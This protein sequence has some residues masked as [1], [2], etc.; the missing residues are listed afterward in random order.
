M[1]T[2]TTFDF[3]KGPSLDGYELPRLVRERRA[4]SPSGVS[5]FFIKLDDDWGLKVYR[6]ADLRDWMMERQGRAAEIGRG[7]AIGEAV[8]I[9]YDYFAYVS[10]VADTSIFDDDYDDDGTRWHDGEI[11]SSYDE[12]WGDALDEL[13]SDL[14][15]IGIGFSD[16]HHGNVGIIDDRLVCIDFGG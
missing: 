8:D 9:G 2:Q 3:V 6:D 13:H 15:S 14:S 10:Q 12:D 5:S 11:I 1:A 4:G 16:D 7:P